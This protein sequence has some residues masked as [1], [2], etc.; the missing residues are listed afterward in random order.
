MKILAGNGNPD[1]ARAIA[2]YLDMELTRASVRR[3]ADGL[4]IATAR[5]RMSPEDKL[6]HVRELQA[7]GRTVA[8]VGDGINDGPVLA[9]ADV[10]F[11]LG[12]GNAMAARAADL[13]LAAPQLLRIP[14]SIALARRTQAIIRQNLGWALAYN[15]IALPAAAM[16]MVT[17][18]QA[19]LGMAV[20]SLI[21]TLN[22]LRLARVRTA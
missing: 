19:A 12:D 6:A 8:M 17:P 14:Q 5:G 9:G 22:A 7:A 21:V 13:V 20:S 11:A 15:L 4:G 2:G 1:L 16:G 10:S 18:W 3:F